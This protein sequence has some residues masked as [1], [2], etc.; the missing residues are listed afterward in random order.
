MAVASAMGMLTITAICRWFWP[1]AGAA[2]CAPDDTSGTRMKRRWPICSSPCLTGWAFRRRRWAT[3]TASWATCPISEGRSRHRDVIRY[4][5][6]MALDLELPRLPE[7]PR[8]IPAGFVVSNDPLLPIV[9]LN[10]VSG[11]KRDIGQQ[12]A[13]GQLM[14]VKH[15]AGCLQVTRFD[16]VEKLAQVPGRVC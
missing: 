4:P 12:T 8:Q 2:R 14:S 15:V 13:F 3:A 5:G 1:A 10:P 11:A 6:G 9:P 16:G 7:S